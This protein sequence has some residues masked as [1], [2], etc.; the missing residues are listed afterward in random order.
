MSGV[1]FVYC[2]DRTYHILFKWEIIFAFNLQ[3]RSKLVQKELFCTSH[4]KIDIV[5]DG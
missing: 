5:Y 1:P 3:Y 2:I 4:T